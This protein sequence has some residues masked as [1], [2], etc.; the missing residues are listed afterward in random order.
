M[1][2]TRV[3]RFRRHGI[4]QSSD[5]WCMRDIEPDIGERRQIPRVGQKRRAHLADGGRVVELHRLIQAF[6]V[7]TPRLTTCGSDA[8][9]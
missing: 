1:G 6:E 2:H 3:S 5:T 4:E 7:Q 9:V 8:R